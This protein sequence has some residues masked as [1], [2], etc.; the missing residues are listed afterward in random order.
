MLE[1]LPIH[2]FTGLRAL[3]VFPSGRVMWPV[4]GGAEDADG[5]AAADAGDRADDDAGGTPA[6]DKPDDAKPDGTS[7]GD[8]TSEPPALIEERNNRKALETVLAEVTGKS[9]S[10]IRRM[11]KKGTSETLAALKPADDKPDDAP[12][13]DAIRREVDAKANT[14]IVRAE[15]R[16]LAAE[17]FADPQDAVLNLQSRLDDFDVDEDGN[18]TDVEDLKTALADLLKRK[19]HLA[20]KGK[21]PKADPSQGSRGDTLP[22]FKT[23]ADRIRWAYEKAPAK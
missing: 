9:K 8:D 10:E 3:H 13:A 1:H 7:T 11:L 21:A 2:P 23:P 22:E 14:R 5:D 12:D 16:A 18:V 19:P 4:V 20:K 6:D 15:V 17:T